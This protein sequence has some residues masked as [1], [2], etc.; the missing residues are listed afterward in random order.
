[1]DL[2]P[3]EES[4]FR[5]VM[6][7]QAAA[8]DRAAALNTYH[9][10]ASILERELG[11]APDRSTV[12]LYQRLVGQATARG[13][14][15]VVRATEP[16]PLVGRSAELAQVW[17][18]WTAA[19]TGRPGLHVVIGD[20]GVGKTRLL[21]EI[22]LRVERSGGRVARARCF[23]GR[24]QLALAP[25]AEWLSSREL[26]AQRD[27]LDP[28]WSSEVERL[29]PSASRPRSGRAQPMVDRWQRHRFFEGLARAVLFGD[30]PTLLLLDDLHWCDAD[31]LT[32]MD[33]LF[34]LGPQ[35]QLLVLAASRVDERFANANTDL[36]DGLSVLRREGQVT[37]TDLAPLDAESTEALA[38]HLGA[39]VRDPSSLHT[40]TGGFPLFVIESSRSAAPSSPDDVGRP[41]DLDAVLSRRLAQVSPEAQELSR[42]AAAVGRDFSLALLTEASDFSADTVVN[43]VDELWRRRLIVQQSGSTYDFAH[44]LIRT[45]AYHQTSP[46]QRTLLHRR[47]AQSMELLHR[48][49]APPAAAI[50]EQY[51]QAGLPAR[52]LAAHV[53]AAEIASALFAYDNAIRHYDQ[54]LTMLALLPPG[55]DRDQDELRICHAMS[56]PLNARFGYASKRL[57][58]ALERAESLSARLGEHRLRLLSLVGLFA[59]KFVQGHTEE[60]YAIGRRS[61]ELSPGHPD[62]AGQAHFAFAGAASSLGH[63]IEAIEHFD[64]VPALTLDSPPAVVGS[65]PEVHARAWSAHSLL[66]VGRGEEARHRATWAIDRAEEVDHPYS[67]AIALAYAAITA[68][69]DGDRANADLLAQRTFELC[70]RYGFAYY[71]EWGVILHGWAQ[72]GP[73]EVEA[74]REALRSLDEQG[75]YARRPYFLYLLAQSLIDDG[76]PDEG[77]AA[78]DAAHAAAAARHDVWWLPEILRVQASMGQASLARDRLHDAH[79]LA[80]RQGSNMLV[81]RIAADAAQLERDGSRT[82][83]ERSVP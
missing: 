20:A 24:S 75:A 32:W 44:D 50:A 25:V 48:D 36:A 62:V 11:V 56:A 53:A 19:L 51:E 23:A 77:T 49:E 69:M 57:Q 55:P 22:G 76:R 79:A 46:P 68:Q 28:V 73:E 66:L 67:L 43:A 70:E 5:T 9:R 17:Q 1:M 38:R 14:P 52:A 83:R 80:V 35:A 60:S 78:L 18:R 31:T 16:L 6:E 21:D 26:T 27:H 13:T 72:G 7:L 39:D 58:V 29:V 82:V 54:A 30:R 33:L 47:L 3:L 15:E 4:T 8:G 59:V 42:L 63:L 71:R 74:I 37:T 41:P 81:A 2:E 64:L 65:R 45:T 40:A 61:L 34:R 10:C 12:A